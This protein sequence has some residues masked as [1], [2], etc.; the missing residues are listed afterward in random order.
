VRQVIAAAQRV[1]GRPI[2]A[3]ETARRAGDPAALVASSEAI[4]RELGW[5]PQYPELDAIIET[6]WDWHRRHPD[7]YSSWKPEVR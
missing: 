2:K 3:V 1:T 5:R 6:A 4:Q 7:G